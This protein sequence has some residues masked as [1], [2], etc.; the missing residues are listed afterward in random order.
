MQLEASLAVAI[1]EG[2]SLAA[3]RLLLCAVQQLWSTSDLSP[4]MAAR[5]KDSP[6][7]KAADSAMVAVE[8]ED[9]VVLDGPDPARPQPRLSDSSPSAGS[10]K[11]LASV[12]VLDDDDDDKCTA[13]DDMPSK[14]EMCAAT[15]GVPLPAEATRVLA[16]AG[17]AQPVSAEPIPLEA[18]ST[19][20]RVEGKT[21]SPALS[22]TRPE[23]AGISA[24]AYSAFTAANVLARTVGEAAEFL[25]KQRRHSEACG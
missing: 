16:D 14:S 4:N 11:Q 13:R 22:I 8:D 15:S 10:G 18:D 17:P 23:Q 7:T 19:C 2:D 21:T 24:H 1:A 12:I 9:C 20:D 6:L 5:Q 25:E 3:D